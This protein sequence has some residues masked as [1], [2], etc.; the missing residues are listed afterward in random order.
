M[1]SCEQL[2][3]RVLILRE[4]I[5]KSEAN[6]RKLAEKNDELQQRVAALEKSME[7]LRIENACLNDRI[8]HYLLRH[9]ARDLVFM[10]KSV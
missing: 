4:M 8:D 10:T 1:A 6:N 5:G 3:E 9:P 7:A 2:Y